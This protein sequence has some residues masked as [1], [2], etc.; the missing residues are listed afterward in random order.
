VGFT[1][2]G[3]ILN[4]AAGLAA[5]LVVARKLNLHEQG[6]YATFGNLLAMQVF[7]ELGLGTVIL[8]SASHEVALLKLDSDG[9]YAGDSESHR[10]LA[11]LLQI[12]AKCYGFIALLFILVLAPIGIL[13]FRGDVFSGVINWRLPW[14]LTVTFTGAFLPLSGATSFIEG[15]GEITD[16]ARIRLWQGLLANLAL[17]TALVLG[18]RLLATSVGALIQVAA[19]AVWLYSRHRPKL[20]NLWHTP[21]VAGAIDWWKQIW[22]FQWRM[23]ISWLSGY[24]IFQ[25][26]TPV[27]FKVQ[28]ADEAGKFGLTFAVISG[29]TAIS[30][31]WITT[32]VPRFGALIALRQYEELDQLFARSTRFVVGLTLLFGAL[33]WLAIAALRHEGFA[34]A[35]RFVNEPTLAMMVLTAV[36]MN[37]S[38]SL[39]SYLRSHKREPFLWPSVILGV[40][41]AGMA[42]LVAKPYG[43]L[44]VA[45]GSFATSLT[46]AV[47]VG[48]WVF[49]RKR[50]E[51]HA[52]KP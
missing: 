22:P 27:L 33:F 36:G 25:L 35:D 13:F 26:F 40:A 48:Y 7:F 10:R 3:R 52:V 4:S 23:A 8:H 17:L 39:A 38:F 9:C 34:L 50:R 45:T 6:Y 32:K 29:I 47:G 37:F 11:D 51:W 18:F 21:D 16:A 24:L 43:A 44:G 15:C 20:A 41:N 30:T 42:L 1:V 49:Q 14:L 2:I 31:S 46:V 12:G 19:A 28:G 5:I